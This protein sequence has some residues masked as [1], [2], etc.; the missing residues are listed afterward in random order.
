MITFGDKTTTINNT[1]KQVARKTLARRATEPRGTLK[2]LWNIIPDGT[3]TNYSP[4]TITLDIHNRKD[5]VIRKND[6]AIV[7]ETKPRLIHFV[8]CKTVRE[9]KR[10]QEKIKEFLL[11]EKKNNQKTQSKEKQQEHNPVTTIHTDQPVPSTSQWNYGHTD[12]PGPSGSQRNQPNKN[13]KQPRRKGTAPTKHTYKPNKDFEVR[14]KEAALAQSRLEKAKQRQ[15]QKANSPRIQLDMKKMQKDKS[16]EIINLASDSSQGSPLQ[17]FTS[18]NPNAFMNDN[19]KSKDNSPT[20]RDAK[21]DKIIKRITNS[22]K[23]TTTEPE[24]DQIITI[25]PA[26]TSTPIGTNNKYTPQRDTDQKTTKPTG[27]DNIIEQIPTPSN[28][29]TQ[30]HP[31]ATKE[32]VDPPEER[33]D[34]NSDRDNIHTEE[35]DDDYSRTSSISSLNTADMEALSKIFD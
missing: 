16:V 35:Q 1:R 27:I 15:K 12:Q 25:I 20:K 34:T 31:Q 9:Y 10:N 11:T 5:T 33:Q 6:L 18:D 19:P 17:I 26:S 2:P 22:P 7:N 3:I 14:S 32:L 30:P 8:A 13:P 28:D 24:M 21:I 4:T 29:K 23:K